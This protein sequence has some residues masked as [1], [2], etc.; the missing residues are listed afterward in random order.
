MLPCTEGLLA[1][2]E[3]TRCP[4]Y[5]LGRPRLLY[6]LIA[7]AKRN[8]FVRDEAPEVRIIV[9]TTYSGDV[10]AMADSP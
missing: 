9:L 2:A 4:M 1:A 10:Q 3:N 5:I 8:A 7:S 6:L